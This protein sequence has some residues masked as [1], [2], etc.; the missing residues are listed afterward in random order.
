D[1]IK[2]RGSPN[3]SVLIVVRDTKQDAK[4]A[5]ALEEGLTANGF[6]VVDTVRGQP[7]DARRAI[8]KASEANERIDWIAGN[9]ATTRWGVFDDLQAIGPATKKAQVIAP[10]TYYGSTFL[11]RENLLNIPNQVAFIAIIAI[12]MTMV[13]I[14]G[15]IDLSVGSVVALST[16]LIARAI[17]DFAGGANASTAGLIVCCLGAVL[18]CGAVGA[19][20][21]AFVTLL[22]IPPFIVTLST[23]SAASGLA[24][25]TTRSETINA[26]PDSML[27]LTGSSLA[28]VPSPVILMLVLYAIG[29]VVLSRTTFGRYL[30]AVGGNRK[31]AWLCG[32]PVR[33]V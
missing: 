3:D 29:H 17:R 20:N 18:L 14:V 28:G 7:A 22:R 5:Q 25:L 10:P 6:R 16:V 15:G 31:A 11:N 8:G 4:F 12:G 30:Y 27:A 1:L 19:L 23:M 24:M 26:I 2:Q 21:G 32:L 9:E 33:R 13:I